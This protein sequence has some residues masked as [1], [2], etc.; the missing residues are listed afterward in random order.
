[1]SNTAVEESDAADAE[2][3]PLRV[4]IVGGGFIG[5]AVGEGFVEHED[6][7]VVAVVDIAEDVLEEAGE[8]LGVDADSQYT[9]YETMLE[10]EELD[11]VLIGTPHTLHYDQILA[12]FERDLHVLCDKPL[13]TD[14][15]DA[16]DLV[17]RDA[18]RDEVLM[19]GYQRHLYPAFR[20]AK[21]VWNEDG[22][23]P[24]WITA[25]VSQD[26]V[27]RFEGA[28]RQDPDLS[29]GG[30]LYDTGSHL[31]DG[32]LW[33][34]GLTPEAVS[35]NMH[36][37]DDEK[38]V[39]GRANVTVRFTNDATATFSLSGETPCM[40]EHVR[41]WDEDGAV[42][43]DS[44]DWEPSEYA[45]IDDE[46]G[47]YRPRLSR[48]DQPTKAEAFVDAIETG[49]RPVATALDGLRVTAVTEAAYESARADGSFVAVDPDDVALDD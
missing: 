14:L 7:A 47:E 9:D 49:E 16:R 27:D 34:T 44:R 8:E 32:V 30:Y 13:T 41:M 15:D 38:R 46:S 19:V 11:A 40:R 25:E 23:E 31:L 48:K 36:F 22:R 29:G 2:H 43:L 26:W 37:L 18:E 12:A 33:S 20:A 5:K 21:E 24:R 6:A 3:A 4:G 45:E 10:A 17:E 42:T 39:D 1:M 28:W 35:A